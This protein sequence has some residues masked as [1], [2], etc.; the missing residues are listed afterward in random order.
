MLFEVEDVKM[1]L[2]GGNV[3]QRFSFLF[4]YLYMMVGDEDTCD[5]A[6]VV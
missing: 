4:L 3:V 5:F 2:V 1:E 6:A